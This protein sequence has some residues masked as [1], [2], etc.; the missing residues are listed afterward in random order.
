MMTLFRSTDSLMAFAQKQYRNL[1]A[2]LC[3]TG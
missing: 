3:F 1:A 2:V